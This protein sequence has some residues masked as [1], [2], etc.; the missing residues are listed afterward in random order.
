MY[1][2]YRYFYEILTMHTKPFSKLLNVKVNF[3]LFTK[4]NVNIRK[5]W[6]PSGKP[7]QCSLKSLNNPCS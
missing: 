6:T 2:I 1:E 7:F 3:T 5:L 4:A